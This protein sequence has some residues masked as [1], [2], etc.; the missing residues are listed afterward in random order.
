MG[1]IQDGW[2]RYKMDGEDKRWMMGKLQNEWRRYMMDGE[3]T[4]W[5]GKVQDGW[6]SYKM[7]GEDTR[8]VG[9]L[10]NEWG[11][12]KMDDGEDTRWMGKIQD[13]WGSYKMDGKDKR[14]MM[15]KYKMNGED[16]RWMEKVQDGWE[17][18][19]TRERMCFVQGSYFVGVS[20]KNMWRSNSFLMFTSTVQ[21][22]PFNPS[23]SISIYTAYWR[24]RHV[25][26]NET[27][28][29]KPSSKLGRENQ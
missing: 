15:G 22:T 21:S 3:G 9:K 13:G 29:I 28:E 11:R 25:M 10:Q 8:W 19:E 17:T 7:D 23:G 14:W 18:E 6:G 2:G 5:M 24:N 26:N 4:R 1:K 27:Y 16:T 20:T 12:Y